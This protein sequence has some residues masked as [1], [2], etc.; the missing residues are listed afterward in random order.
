MHYGLQRSTP[1]KLVY[2]FITCYNAL[3]KI[4]HGAISECHPNYYSITYKNT[5][6]KNTPWRLKNKN[7]GGNLTQNRAKKYE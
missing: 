6:S 2:T 5:F 3:I 4:K 1:D 7:F